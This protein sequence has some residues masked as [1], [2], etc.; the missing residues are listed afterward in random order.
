MR[1]ATLTRVTT[2]AA[3]AAAAGLALAG[4]ASAATPA[5]VAKT[6]L[7]ITEVKDVITG[8]LA[9]GKVG[10]AK[11]SVELISIAAK[12]STVIAKATTNKDGVVAFTVKP[13]TTTTYELVFLGGKGLAAAH[14]ADVTVK[15]AAAKTGVAKK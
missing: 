4:T 5:P 8:T 13:K 6:T 9:E 10:L 2:V 3:L 15:P 14:S 1:T 7:K 11:E 12:K